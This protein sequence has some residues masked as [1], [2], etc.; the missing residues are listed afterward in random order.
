MYL[1]HFGVYYIISLQVTVT[2]FLDTEKFWR[3]YTEQM[4]IWKQI[5]E[6]TGQRIRVNLSLCLIK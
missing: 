6:G 5:V 2:V 4:S 1:R 3:S